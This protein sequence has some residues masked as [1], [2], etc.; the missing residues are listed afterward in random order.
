MTVED[1][2]RF[3]QYILT[4]LTVAR[5]ILLF[6]VIEAIWRQSVRRA[7]SVPQAEESTLCQLLYAAAWGEMR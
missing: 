7:L 3:C 2:Y 6:H 5:D 4:S 1:S